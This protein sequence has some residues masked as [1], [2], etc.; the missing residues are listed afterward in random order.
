MEGVCGMIPFW[1]PTVPN[2]GYRLFSSIFV[3]AGIIHLFVTLLV[4]WFIMRDL[5]KLSGWFRIALI[6][7]ISGVAGNI[8]SSIFQSHV[9][10]V[11]PYGSQF[12]LLGTL[13]M[14]VVN[15][16]GMLQNPVHDLLRLLAT[17]L[18]LLVIGILPWFDNYSAIGG[19]FAGF[20]TAGVLQPYTSVGDP[21]RVK[22]L[23][24]TI[25]SAVLLAVM[26]TVLFVCM[27]NS[28][29]MELVHNCSWCGYFNCVPFT[30]D[31]CDQNSYFYPKHYAGLEVNGGSVVDD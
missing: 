21:T 16:W 7:L 8:L 13:I 30:S 6:Y 11:G 25:I 31:F 12:G 17:A 2:Q 19:L 9:A 3:H 23:V 5:E 24:T 26:L 20:F 18:A 1:D 29:I 14:E 4:Q 10:S 27:Y 28:T 22:Y 15:S